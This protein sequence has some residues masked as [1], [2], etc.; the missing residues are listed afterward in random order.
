M[1]YYMNFVC[2]MTCT[3]NCHVIVDYNLEFKK[4]RIVCH[5]LSH[6]DQ[7]HVQPILKSW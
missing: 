6:Y 1:P 3:T 2:E 7:S 4:A 5:S